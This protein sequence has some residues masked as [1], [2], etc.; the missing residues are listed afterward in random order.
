MNIKPED[1]LAICAFLTVL[2]G[3]FLWANRAMLAPFKV[4]I[5]ANTDAMQSLKDLVAVHGDKLED[6]GERIA[7]IETKHAVR[8]PGE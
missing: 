8:H 5:S 1:I 6:H 2:G 7:K 4:L 3:I